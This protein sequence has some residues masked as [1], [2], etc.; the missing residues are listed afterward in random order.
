M[1]SEELAT[2]ASLSGV[3]VVLDSVEEVGFGCA[4]V[5]DRDEAELSAPSAV[6]FSV[7]GGFDSV[8]LLDLLGAIGETEVVVAGPA[9]VDAA[10]ALDELS[11]EEVE[12][13]DKDPPSVPFL[14]PFPIDSFI[15]LESKALFSVAITTNIKTKATQTPGSFISFV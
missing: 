13:D 14:F 15:T 12:D 11:F 10:A 4:D 3:E 1:T 9:E 6:G 8:S 2:E 5:L 7:E